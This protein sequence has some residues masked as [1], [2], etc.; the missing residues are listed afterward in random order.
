MHFFL[1]GGSTLSK[2]EKNNLTPPFSSLPF[3][4]KFI[5][6]VNKDKP[7]ILLL[8][9]AQEKQ[10]KICVGEKRFSMQFKDYLNCNTDVLYLSQNPSII[11]I[12]KKLAWAD[13]FYLP[14]GDPIQLL[15]VWKKQG[16]IELFNQQ[17]Q[18]NKPVFAISAGAMCLFEYILNGEDEYA[19]IEKNGL[20]FIQGLCMPHFNRNELSMLRM[21]LLS[22]NR[23]PVWGIDDGVV[24]EIKNDKRVVWSI[25]QDRHVHYSYNGKITILEQFTLETS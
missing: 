20:N 23:F 11:Q 18:K 17:I 25:Y 6:F 5:R 12:K 2:E 8:P 7:N 21:H 22:Q 3:D 13:C 15:Q 16:F 19:K 1:L 14:G 9:T 10:G 4:L 24:L